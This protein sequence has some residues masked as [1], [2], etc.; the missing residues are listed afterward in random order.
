MTSLDLPRTA[1]Y[2]RRELDWWRLGAGRG[3]LVIRLWRSCRGPCEK[4]AY[5]VEADLD[6]LEPGW[7]RWL[8]LNLTDRTQGDV[9]EVVLRPDGQAQSCTCLG[10]T[11]GATAMCKHLRALVELVR[12]GE[13]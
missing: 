9:Y 3:F 12:C 5:G 4:D 2:E 10:L 6:G 7:G 8:L 1:S 13:L 11:G